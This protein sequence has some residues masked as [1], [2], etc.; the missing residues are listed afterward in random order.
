[1][2]WLFYHRLII[3]SAS[4]TCE[5]APSPMILNSQSSF[6]SS[7]HISDMGHVENRAPVSL[8][9][10][11]SLRSLEEQ[12]Y[13]WNLCRPL[14][15]SWE[16]L[17]LRSP[18]VYT[19]NCKAL[20]SGEVE[21]GEPGVYHPELRSKFGASLCYVRPCLKTELYSSWSGRL[22]LD[23]VGMA[24]LQSSPVP[25]P[26]SDVEKEKQIWLLKRLSVF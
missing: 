8:P 19:C 15:A 18:L 22:M 21:A 11:W 13:W 5:I 17:I 3:S 1:M 26:R 20:E 9:L 24:R 6:C 4:F 2:L 7:L 14:W 10:S 25:M 23:I 12:H 16:N